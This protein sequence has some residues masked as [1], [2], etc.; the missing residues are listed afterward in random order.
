MKT[1]FIINK[2]AG[3]KKEVENLI[4][5]IPE[6]A[7]VYFTKCKGD[8]TRFVKE[9]CENYGPARFIACGGDGTIN[10]VVNGVLSC[11]GAESGVVPVG[12]GNDFVRNFSGCDFFDV[13]LQMSCES[14]EVDVIHY[15]SYL[16][17]R[18]TGGYG[19]NMFN[20]GFDC[21]VADKKEQLTFIPGALA[22]FVSIFI[23][24]IAK[25]GAEVKI[26]TDGECV[27]NGKLLLTSVA[28]GCYCGGGIKS[29]PL[30]HIKNG[31]INVN[32]VKNI[33]RLRF[34]SL[35]PKYMKGTH[36]NIKNIEKI[37]AV[38]MCDE[39][40]VTPL[41]GKMKFCV[42]G[43]ILSTEKIKFEIKP[44]KLKFAVPKRKEHSEYDTKTSERLGV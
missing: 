3:Q 5:K 6:T 40:T 39:I 41:N 38:K 14:Q 25:K 31:L 43:E 34:I 21:N 12:T 19:V 2:N 36:I 29:N 10:E 44:Q 13:S 17:G 42:D 26:E 15:T 24:L 11:D 4:R 20:I 1:V 33:S 28:N 16:N 32:I 35:L 8:A 23:N 9:Y 30:S 37:I 22:Y 7:E 18:E 27:H